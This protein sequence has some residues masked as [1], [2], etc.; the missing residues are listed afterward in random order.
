MKGFTN[1]TLCNSF[2]LKVNSNLIIQAKLFGSIDP[3]HNLTPSSG[4]CK[5]KILGNFISN[6]RVRVM[7]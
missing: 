4:Y 3:N 5:S 2:E 7:L 6:I 1:N